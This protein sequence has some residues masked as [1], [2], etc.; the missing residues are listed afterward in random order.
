MS[1]GS[2]STMSGS[3]SGSIGE[4]CTLQQDQQAKNMKKERENSLPGFAEKELS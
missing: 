4:G 2:V 3:G 1:L